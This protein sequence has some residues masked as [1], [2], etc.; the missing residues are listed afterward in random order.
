MKKQAHTS[1]THHINGPC[2]N[3]LTHKDKTLNNG[4]DSMQINREVNNAQVISDKRVLV[5]RDKEDKTKDSDSCI[6][7]RYGRTIRKS[8]RLVY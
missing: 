2:T 6:R 7:T 5:N 3:N 4:K 8:D 1:N